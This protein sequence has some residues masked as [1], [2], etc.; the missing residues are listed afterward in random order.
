MIEGFDVRLTTMLL[1]LLHPTTSPWAYT[2]HTRQGGSDSQGYQ[3]SFELTFLLR[4][5]FAV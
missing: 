3:E 5:V 1:M 4:A 2:P